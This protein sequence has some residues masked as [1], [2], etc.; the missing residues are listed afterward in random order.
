MKN[1]CGTKCLNPQDLRMLELMKLL[2]CHSTIL[3]LHIAHIC[4]ELR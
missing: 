1:I 3:V 4:V 2:D